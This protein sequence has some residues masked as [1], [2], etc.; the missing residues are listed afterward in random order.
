MGA[1]TGRHLHLGID[2]LS[3]DSESILIDGNSGAGV[4]GV[5]GADAAVGDSG[6]LGVLASDMTSS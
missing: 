4:P 2:F 3:Y 6:A 1:Y 5:A